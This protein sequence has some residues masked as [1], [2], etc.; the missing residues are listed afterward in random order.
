[1]THV[2]ILATSLKT[3]SNSQKLA[4]RFHHLLVEKDISAEL[5]DF[6]TLEM[7]FAGSPDSWD[8]PVILSIKEAV[9]RASHIVFATPI[10]C[11]DV[12]AVAKTIIELTGRSFTEKVVGFICSAGGQGSY[13]SVMGMANHLMLDFRTVIVPR[14]VYSTYDD[15]DEAGNLNAELQER[16]SWLV[17]DLA[18][19]QVSPRGS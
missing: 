10:Y 17:E 6:R 7:T 9:E 8:Q 3:D 2:T 1:M 12:N 15:W 18:S 5:L 11:Y 13:M 14:F 4:K 19:I 16:L